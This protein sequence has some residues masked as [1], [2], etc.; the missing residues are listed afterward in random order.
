MT[1]VGSLVSDVY[2]YTCLCTGVH[3]VT[4]A[5]LTLLEVLVMH[6]TAIHKVLL[7]KNVT[8]SLGSVVAFLAS[9]AEDVTS[10]SHDMLLLMVSAN[11]RVYCLGL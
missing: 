5:I 9:E 8:R 11:V 7:V 10:V 1:A 2:K 4:M 6:V 3:L